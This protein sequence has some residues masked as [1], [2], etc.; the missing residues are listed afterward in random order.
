MAPVRDNIMKSEKGFSLIESI[1]ALALLGIIGASFLGSIG[2]SAKATMVDEDRTIAESLARGQVE[3]VK[4]CT[5]EYDA[6]D[7]S[8]DPTIDIPSGWAIPNSTVEPVHA[9]DD[10]IQK[11]TV[12]VQ[13]DSETVFSVLVYKADR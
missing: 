8:V 3:Y 9:S 4:G 2:T 6:T 7:Y 1:V 5:Y 12:T 10:G 11:V 13:H